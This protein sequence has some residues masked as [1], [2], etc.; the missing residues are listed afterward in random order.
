MSRKSRPLDPQIS[1]EEA[2]LFRTAVRDTRT[3]PQSRVLNRAPPPPPRA[4][5]RRREDAEVLRELHDS[6]PTAEDVETG[7]ELSYARPGLRPGILRRLRRGHFP[8]EAELDLHGLT[9]PHARR[10]LAEFLGEC[11][12]NGLRCVRIVHGKGLR[13]AHRGPVLK[14]KVNS[15]LRRRDEV[16][17]FVSARPTDGGTGA[18][19]LLLK[20]H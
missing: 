19:Y 9:V 10:A 5:F 4:D 12:I 18:I 17:A 6:D 15:W 8:I 3:L 2:A 14:G 7:E 1:E 20:W 16:L 11:R 13:S